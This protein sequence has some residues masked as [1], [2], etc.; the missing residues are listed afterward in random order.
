MLSNDRTSSGAAMSTP[1]N[2]PIPNANT[3]QFQAFIDTPPETARTGLSSS[4]IV[5]ICAVAVLLVL[6]VI[7]IAVF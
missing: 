6:A 2:E 1:T 7:G 4:T 5:V 3:A